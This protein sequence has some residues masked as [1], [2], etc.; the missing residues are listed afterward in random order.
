MK[1]NKK[2]ILLSLVTAMVVTGASL[3]SLGFAQTTTL[4]TCTTAGSSVL[5]NQAAILTANGGNGTYFWSG[6]NLNVG[7]SAGNQF[8]VSYPTVGTYSVQ[9]SS[10]GQT[11][12]CTVNVVGAPAT[13]ALICFPAAQNVILGQSISVTATGGNGT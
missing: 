2:Y 5:V 12:S 13:G 8:A 10:V 9:V 7:N 4:V 11:A 1:T 3:G 6:Q